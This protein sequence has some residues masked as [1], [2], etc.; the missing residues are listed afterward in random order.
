[1]VGLLKAIQRVPALLR[2]LSPRT[3]VQRN[4]RVSITHALLCSFNLLLR[5]SFDQPQ[6]SE[7]KLAGSVWESNPRENRKTKDLSEHGWQL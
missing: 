2:H 3:K 7:N 5:H 4:Y 6:L 1:M